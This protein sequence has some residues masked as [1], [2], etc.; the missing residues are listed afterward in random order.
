MKNYP[1]VRATDDAA[2][3]PH[4][5]RNVCLPNG[6]LNRTA[7]FN[8]FLDMASQMCQTFLLSR[9]RIPVIH[10]EIITH[11]YAV[12]VFPAIWFPV[13]LGLGYRLHET[14]KNADW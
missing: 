10:L 9:H 14:D 4:L 12:E 1:H 6:D 5:P 8:Q 3:M 11:Q 2:E 13:R 7:K